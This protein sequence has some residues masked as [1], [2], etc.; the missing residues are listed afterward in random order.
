MDQILPWIMASSLLLNF[1]LVIT[2]GFVVYKLLIKKN[3]ANSPARTVETSNMSS[4]LESIEG[5]KFEKRSSNMSHRVLL[6]ENVQ[7]MKQMYEELQS[8]RGDYCVDHPTEVSVG[9]C[10]ISGFR[11]CQHCLKV[12][13][14]IKFG[15][16]YLNIY[17]SSEWEDFMTIAKTDGFE[18]VSP[19]I[20]EL[21]KKLWENEHIP[22]IV[23][24]HFKI[25]LGDDSIEA[26]TVLKGRKSEINYLT[27]RFQKII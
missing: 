6:N 23:Q 2:V 24:S 14:N 13:Q 10:S 25:N 18:D 22:V 15:K 16:K 3:D 11:Y 4:D 26:F 12:F 17:L 9:V 8:N 5:E 7:A 19:A 27:D 1:I 21:K 20:I